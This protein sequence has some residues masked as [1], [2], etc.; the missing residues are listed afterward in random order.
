MLAVPSSKDG[1]KWILHSV[2]IS[3]I[4]LVRTYCR[5]TRAP[6]GGIL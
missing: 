3:V 1:M 2:E 6:G 5:H 4:D